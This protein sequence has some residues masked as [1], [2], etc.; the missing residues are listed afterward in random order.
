MLWSDEF[1][2]LEGRPDPSIWTFSEG[3]EASSMGWGAGDL[4]Y[5]THYGENA[6][7]S[8]GNLVLRAVRTPEGHWTGSRLHTKG[9]KEWTYGRCEIRAR[10]P[11]AAGA[12]PSIRLLPAAQTY[13]KRMWPDNGEIDI[14]EHSQLF[15][16]GMPFGAL[17][18]AAGSG[19]RGW[20]AGRRE[21]RESAGDFHVY[22]LEWGRDRIRWEYDGEPFSRE[23]PRSEGDG[24]FWWPFDQPFYLS[25]SL[26]MGGTLGGLVDPVLGEAVM[27]IDWVRVY[28]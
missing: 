25:I 14:M 23:Y 17:H 24:W 27:E 28:R 12:W 7:V 22:A 10:L 16:T 20:Q 11:L 4:R 21:Y 9:K 5:Y 15:G 3:S 18:R 1:Q 8:G 6:F 26:S 2:G 13:G 19:P